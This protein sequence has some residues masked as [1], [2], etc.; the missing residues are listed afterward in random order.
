MLKA[1]IKQTEVRVRETDI[2]VLSQIDE[3]L[4]TRIFGDPVRLN[5]VL[6]NILDNAAKNTLQGTIQLKVFSYRS[7]KRCRSNTIYN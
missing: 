7:K 5:Q 2:E 4:P 3:N 6:V 1:A